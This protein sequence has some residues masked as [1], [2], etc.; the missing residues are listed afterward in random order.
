MTLIDFEVMMSIK[1]QTCKNK[2]NMLHVH[3]SRNK[4]VPL[5][6]KLKGQ[7][8]HRICPL[9]VSLQVITKLKKKTSILKLIFVAWFQIQ[10]KKSKLFKCFY[11]TFFSYFK[12]TYYWYGVHHMWKRGGG[13]IPGIYLF[14]FYTIGILFF[15]LLHFTV[16]Y[17]RAN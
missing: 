16:V 10:S 2:I 3:Q 15:L 14:I 7:T 12:C 9:L 1:R 4:Q 11:C 8:G 17:G 6:S 13:L 5:W